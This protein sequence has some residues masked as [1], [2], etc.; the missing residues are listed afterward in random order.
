M[1]AAAT[2][3]FG[4]SVGLAFG[5]IRSTGESC[6]RSAGD[7]MVASTTIVGDTASVFAQNVGTANAVVAVAGIAII[8]VLGGILAIR[9]RLSIDPRGESPS[10]ADESQDL[11]TDR[12]R[13]R[14]LVVDNGGRM[15]QAEIVDRVEWSKAKVSR[16]LAD[17]EDDDE[18]TKLRLG[19]ENLIC[20]QGHE[21][22]ASKSPEGASRH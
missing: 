19:R 10:A 11:L 17:L 14:Q 3:V 16:L 6:L 13:I 7:G 21:P 9:N 20:L 4:G 15:K 8:A 18:I 5:R 22:P 12:E 1:T 2:P